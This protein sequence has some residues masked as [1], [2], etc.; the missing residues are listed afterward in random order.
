MRAYGLLLHDLVSR[1]KQADE[2]S[3]KDTGR[4]LQ[5]IVQQCIGNTT[6]TIQQPTFS[7]LLERL[8]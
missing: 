4:I 8:T 2:Q 6:V 5:K 1:L 7:M 3:D